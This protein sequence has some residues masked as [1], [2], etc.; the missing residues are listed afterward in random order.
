MKRL[1]MI[2]LCA[3]AAAALAGTLVASAS[4]AVPTWYECAKAA[5]V[6]REYTGD[7]NN[8]TCTSPN[9]EGKGEFV[10]REGV[11]RDRRIK[12]KSGPTVLHVQTWAGDTLVECKRS[13]FSGVPKLPNFEGGVELLFFQCTSLGHECSSAGARQRGEVRLHAMA[14]ELG[15]LEESP[16]EVGLRLELE[17]SPGGVL[18]S[19][20]CGSFEATLSGALIGAQEK[21]VNAISRPV[22]LAFTVAENLG[23]VEAEGHKFAP[24]VN[25]VGWQSELEAIGKGEAPARVLKGT[26]CGARVESLQ[27]ERCAEAFAGLE[28]TTAT[29]FG[30]PLMVK[31]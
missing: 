9:A 21:D 5:Q 6:G 25:P 12:S 24:L 27:G 22:Q 15:Y 4:A 31:A 11:K 20:S 28:E 18:V 13:N 7:F 8:N 26:M 16:V 19:F 10:L 3:V 30:E 2:W 23:E 14:G 29:P 1:R 17:S